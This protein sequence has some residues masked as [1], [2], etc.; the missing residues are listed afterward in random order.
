[1]YKYLYLFFLLAYAS[2]GFGSQ[3]YVSG[4]DRGAISYEPYRPSKPLMWTAKL[5]ADRAF[6][7]GYESVFYERH[8]V[9]QLLSGVSAGYMET[10]EQVPDS[11]YV[12][13]VYVLAKL[14]L[15]HSRV[16]DFVLLYSPAGPSMLS[17]NTFAT[18]AFTNNFVFQN[19]LGL[20]VSF[21]KEKAY[22]CFAKMYHYSNGDTFPV[23]GGIDIPIV[24]GLIIKL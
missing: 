2:F 7:V 16:F 13:S 24:V 14:S 18:T 4:Y 1:M 23:N 19:Q 22:E 9:F 6:H 10:K 21:G 5:S 17:K 15:I 12:A 11:I 8:K 3:L 20:G